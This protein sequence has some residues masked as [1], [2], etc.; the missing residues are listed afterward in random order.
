METVKI[1]WDGAAMKELLSGPLGPVSRYMETRAAIVT[2]A[3]K[4]QCNWRTG[5]LSRS[6]VQRRAFGSHGLEV[7]VGAYQPYALYVHNGTR[8]HDIP[9]AFG[10]GPTFGIGGRFDGYFHP[11][12]VGNPFLTDNLKLFFA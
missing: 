11:G 10:W 12:Y 3:A 9:N 1:I 4:R 6:I 7:F 5:K 2:L 8:P